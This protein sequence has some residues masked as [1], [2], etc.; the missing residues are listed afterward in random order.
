MEKPTMNSIQ[1]SVNSELYLKDPYTSKLGVEI[2]RQ[3]L[4]L[5][6]ELGYEDFTFKKLALKIKTTEASIYRY[7]ESKHLFLLYLTNWH[8]SWLDYQLK[9]YTT[10]I[11]DPTEKMKQFIRLISSTYEEQFEMNFIPLNKLQALI[12]SE[13]PK[14]YLTRNIDLE[15]KNGFFISYKNI[16][17]SISQL[18]LE[19]NPRFKFA[20][21]LVS[22]CIETVWLQRF[23]SAHL[24]RLSD[25][26]EEDAKLEAF[27]TQLCFGMI[28]YSPQTK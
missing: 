17:E 24:P 2:L 27:C 21:S 23:F 4:D 28:H 5:M 22:T 18:I 13:Y 12:V 7:Y 25:Q 3:G 26:F 8:W 19:I 16:V 11:D 1:I 6:L 10:N 14:T 9:L 20:H 15:N